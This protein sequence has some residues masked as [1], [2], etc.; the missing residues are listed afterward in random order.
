[1][2]ER[3]RAISAQ[4]AGAALSAEALAGLTHLMRCGR[5][6]DAARQVIALAAK[7]NGGGREAVL[8]SVIAEP[9]LNGALAALEQWLDGTVDPPAA[10]PLGAWWALPAAGLDLSAVA[11]DARL[12]IDAYPKPGLVIGNLEERAADWLVRRIA[13]SFD[14]SAQLPAMREAIVMLAGTARPAFP[15]TSASFDGV[16]SDVEDAT[17]WGSLVRQIVRAEMERGL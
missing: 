8:A 13:L 15:T 4:A 5:T 14:A 10:V 1:M 9:Q 6:A 12:Y 11:A 7:G 16:V 3:D 2:S 17:L